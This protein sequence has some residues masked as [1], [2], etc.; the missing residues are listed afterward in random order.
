MQVALGEI[1]KPVC[2]SFDFNIGAFIG[3]PSCVQN[4]LV[5]ADEELIRKLASVL[6]N[7]LLTVLET[8]SVL[9]FT[10]ARDEIWP[11]Y[12]RARRAFSDTLSNIASENTIQAIA[13]ECVSGLSEDFQKQ[14]G[15]RF[16]DA[17]TDQGVFTL[18]TF[19]KINAL[20]RTVN[21][22]G[23]PR[24]KE[25][26][27]RLH[28]EYSLCSLW[29]TFHLDLAVTAMKFKKTIPADIQ[30]AICEGLRIAVNVYAILKDALALRVPQ[31]EAPLA[32]ALPWDEEDEKLLALSMKDINADF[33]EDS[34]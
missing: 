27:R 3:E 8:R 19:G 17:L 13:T 12:I 16:G 1:P 18:W 34:N 10:K 15:V 30:E 21:S 26:D 14:R 23:E 11:K 25:A 28:S 6:D 22:A 24:D 2:P 7:Q 32:S 31:I 20:A 5:R 9:E 33:S 29:A 4:D